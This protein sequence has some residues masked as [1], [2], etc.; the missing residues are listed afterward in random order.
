MQSRRVVALVSLAAGVIGLTGSVMGDVVRYRDGTFAAH[1]A[2]LIAIGEGKVALFRLAAVADLLGSYLLLI[3]AA[4]LLWRWLRPGYG[5]WVDVLTIAGVSYCVVGAAGA[6]VR[7]AAGPPLIRQYA[8]TSGEHAAQIATVF[9]TMSDV[10][11]GIWQILAALLG[12]V[13]WLGIGVITRH[14]WRWFGWFSSLLGS[15]ALLSALGRSL[16]LEYESSGPAA[17]AFAPIALWAAW[18]GVLLWSEQWLDSDN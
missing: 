15:T 3:P 6:A 5:M 7:G 17:P 4:V 11:G 16:G 2:D 10:V 9:A 1:S 8:H 14:R 18:L 12:G 13:W